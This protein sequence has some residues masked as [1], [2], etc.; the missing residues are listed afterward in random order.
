MIFFFTHRDVQP[1]EKN[2]SYKEVF[3]PEKDG[4]RTV[5]VSF[6]SKQLSDIKN[7]VTTTVSP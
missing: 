6:N 1:N 7:T 3:T 4:P 5:T 2:V